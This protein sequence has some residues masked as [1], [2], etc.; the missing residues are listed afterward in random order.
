MSLKTSFD[1]LL[2]SQETSLNRAGI[3]II[4]N[5]VYENII[6]IITKG[7]KI[8]MINDMIKWKPVLIG[9]II[10]SI[11]YVTSDIVSGQN[12]LL[13]E[14]LL[15]GIIVGFIIGGDVK[16]GAINGALMGLITGALVTVILLILI[17]SQGYAGMLEAMIGTI[18]LYIGIEIVLG[19]IGGV[20]GSII[21][22]ESQKVN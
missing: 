22:S 14:F 17:Y 9:I 16:K 18:L 2:Y 8:N 10:A 5:R 21:K 6:K 3:H 19:V 20:T 12:M 13:S 15:G 7:V 4:Q 1:P 11:L